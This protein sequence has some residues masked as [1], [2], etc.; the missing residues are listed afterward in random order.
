M[1]IEF[2]MMARTF[3]VI[4]FNQRNN[5]FATTMALSKDW[6][7]CCGSLQALEILD[8]RTAWAIDW[9]MVS[10]GLAN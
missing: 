7:R 9:A 8:P 3:Q 5:V 2:Y 10:Y 4:D 1:I 6:P